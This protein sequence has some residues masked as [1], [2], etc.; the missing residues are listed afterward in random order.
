[1]YSFQIKKLIIT[2]ENLEFQHYQP[3][4]YELQCQIPGDSEPICFIHSLGIPSELYRSDL[5]SQVHSIGCQFLGQ[6]TTS[7]LSTH[8]QSSLRP[9]VCVQQSIMMT[10]AGFHVQKM[11][12]KATFWIVCLLTHISYT[13]THC[14]L[15]GKLLASSLRQVHPFL[16]FRGKQ[17]LGVQ[18][19]DFFEL[20]GSHSKNPSTL[21]Y[22][23]TMAT[24]HSQREVSILHIVKGPGTVANFL[25][26]ERQSLAIATQ[27]CPWLVQ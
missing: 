10:K 11:V 16:L 5:L 26:R 22:G 15:L 12:I 19:E 20:H 27:L 2:T 25:L 23:P 6:E 17:S 14:T 9:P 1:M 13:L 24:G 8:I 21:L 18:Q 4:V 7:Y 3:C